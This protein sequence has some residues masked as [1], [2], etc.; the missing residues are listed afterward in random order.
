MTPKLQDTIAIPIANEPN[1]TYA[2]LGWLIRRIQSGMIQDLIEHGLTPDLIERLRHLKA[3]ELTELAGSRQPLFSIVVQSN[4]TAPSV[5][6]MEYVKAGADVQKYWITNG[7][8]VEL[9]RHF[10]KLS[11]EQAREHRRFLCANDQM[12]MRLPSDRECDAIYK[13]WLVL[14]RSLDVRVRYMLLHQSAAGRQ[15]TIRALVFAVKRSEQANLT[16]QID[17]NVH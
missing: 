13:A 9:M 11:R 6:K 4:H 2:L 12:N 10:F 14:D 16:H 17:N 7:A 3:H 5:A 8:T 1:L 15:H